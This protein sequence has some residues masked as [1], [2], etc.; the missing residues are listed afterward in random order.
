MRPLTSALLASSLCLALTGCPTTVTCGPDE[1]YDGT[2]CV[3]F[4]GGNIDAGSDGGSEDP[5]VPCGGG[6]TDG[7]CDFAANACV[8]CTADD[9]S[10]CEDG[11]NAC[12]GNT[13]VGCVAD[14]DCA[15][16]SAPE[17]GTDNT[18]GTCTSNDACM[19]RA[20]TTVCDLESGACVECTS[21]ADCT[22]TN[23]GCDVETHACRTYVPRSGSL[24][25][26]CVADQECPMGQLCI[27]MMYDDPATTAA[28]PVFAGNHCL[29]RSDATAPGP[30]DDCFSVRPYVATRPLTSVDGVSTDLCT[31]AVSTCEAHDDFR[32]SAIT[33]TLDAAGNALCGREGVPDA[34]C[35]ST[36]GPTN[37]CTV[38][39]G[40]DDD[41][42]AGFTCDSTTTP[43]QCRL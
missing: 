43:G 22:G 27:P 20:G 36:G 29:W 16:P 9:L 2:M 5:D 33:C 6:C 15:A 40:S 21:N 3:P 14:G 32:S 41:C 1:T 30:A 42:R 37:R 38:Y 11:E 10:A 26:G 34:V 8:E 7:V 39:C 28:D 31:L 25:G 23:E 13:C 35:R 24:C 4:D 18:C 12:A 17:C 19:D